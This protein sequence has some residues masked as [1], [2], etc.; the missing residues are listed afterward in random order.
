MSFKDSV[1]V[2]GVNL[3]MYAKILQTT[4]LKRIGC[5]L[6]NYVYITNKHFFETLMIVEHISHIHIAIDGESFDI[7]CIEIVLSNKNFKNVDIVLPDVYGDCTTDIA[8]I[9]SLLKKHQH[10]E[11]LRIFATTLLNIEDKDYLSVKNPIA[12]FDVRL[13]K[14]ESVT[15]FFNEYPELYSDAEQDSDPDPWNMDVLPVLNTKFLNTKSVSDDNKQTNQDF[16]NEQLNEIYHDEQYDDEYDEQYD[17]Q[18]DE[19]YDEQYDEQNEY[20]EYD[21]TYQNEYDETYQNEYDETYQN[22]YDEYYEFYEQYEQYDKYD[23]DYILTL[24]FIS[25]SES[26][27]ED[28]IKNSGLVKD[29]LVLML[30]HGCL[31]QNTKGVN[32]LTPEQQEVVDR[33]LNA[34]YCTTKSARN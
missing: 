23:S 28:I 9:L 22:D 30:S 1:F 21:E 12:D 32:L 34:K 4:Q 18:Y 2:N 8:K 19:T 14:P 17:E 3:N 13:T 15:Q 5:F 7:N 6:N 16:H 25:L 20:D 26:E 31:T 10:I 27:L 24:P 11:N 29:G 33:E